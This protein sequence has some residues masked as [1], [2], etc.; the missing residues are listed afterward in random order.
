[1]S[2][3][4]RTR[5]WTR[6]IALVVLGDVTVRAI[7]D[8]VR[9]FEEVSTLS[10]VRTSSVSFQPAPFDPSQ[11]TVYKRFTGGVERMMVHVFRRAVAAG[12][13]ALLNHRSFL[14]GP[15]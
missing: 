3:S 8:R 12:R 5:G 6:D 2:S 4:K 9:G 7:Q 11:H 1:M 14:H 13:G 15:R 10:P